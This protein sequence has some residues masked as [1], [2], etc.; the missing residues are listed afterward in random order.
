M[1]QS[2]VKL[3]KGQSRHQMGKSISIVRGLEE[4]TVQCHKEIVW[5]KLNDIINWF[6]SILL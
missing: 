2:R 4:Y 5:I 1:G 3:S 6:V